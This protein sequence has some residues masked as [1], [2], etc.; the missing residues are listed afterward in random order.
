MKHETATTERSKTFWGS[1]VLQTQTKMT[2]KMFL[3]AFL[4]VLA[5][6][7]LIALFYISH[8]YGISNVLHNFS[9]FLQAEFAQT[10]GSGRKFLLYSNVQHTQGGYYPASVAISAYSSWFT[11]FL[12]DIFHKSLYII[13]IYPLGMFFIL[14]IFR[15]KSKEI[16]KKDFHRG[17]QVL[18][19]S[20]L[21]DKIPGNRL[22]PLLKGLA[23][24]RDWETTHLLI[25]GKTGAGKT[26]V[27]NQQLDALRKKGQQ[28]VIVYDYK[29]D[30]IQRFFDEDKDIL[31][32]PLDARC[33][34]WNVFN[35]IEDEM[36][37]Q[38]FATSLIPPSNVAQTERYWLD[39]ARTLLIGLLRGC[40]ADGKT[41]N[42]GLWQVLQLQGK[43][44]YNYLHEHKEFNAC[45]Y[46]DPA[47]AN[48]AAGMLSTLTLFTQIFEKMQYI[49]GDFSLNKWLNSDNTGWL[50]L[51][52]HEKV[53]KALQPI[54]SLPIDMLARDVLTMTDDLNRRI[55]FFLDEFGTLQYL[56]SVIRFLTGARS[57][58]GALIAGT[59]D[60][61]RLRKLYGRDL[62]DTILV[63]FTNKLSLS[64]EGETAEIISRLIGD[65]EVTE[66]NTRYS[67]GPEDMRDG[68]TLD[69]QRKQKRTVLASEIGSLK[70]FEAY[71]ML[72][73]GMLAKGKVKKKF[74]SARKDVNIYVPTQS[75]FFKSNTS[76]PADSESDV[77]VAE[78][79]D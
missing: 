17:R 65:S 38:S 23:L 30:Y 11:S 72:K 53:I 12:D 7:I 75:V 15:K 77:K 40:I 62:V 21:S 32:N 9:V 26:T 24:P 63:N 14:S 35:D 3:D 42:K 79:I 69:K 64:V 59:Q 74:I 57:K 76:S 18:T 36:D 19:V 41:T 22:L 47:A 55:F 58:G 16:A 66:T 25:L 46:I 50:F 52:G 4:L 54:L 51:T 44:M 43:E 20:K 10:V 37:L 34:K 73:N 13:F 39:G 61:G 1:E 67:M 28:K 27:I 71:V 68:I 78:T 33:A 31:F 60:V 8:K 2:I 5:V 56:P 48:Q 49:D 6:N 29:G 45:K 70:Q